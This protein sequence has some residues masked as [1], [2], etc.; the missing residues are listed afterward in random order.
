MEQI[1]E[2]NCMTRDRSFIET[3]ITAFSFNL[4]Q[5]AGK[6]QLFRDL[7]DILSIGESSVKYWKLLM[8]EKREMC[9]RDSA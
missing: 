3:L 9:I 2:T 6:Q 7:L 8:K 1:S 5:A 4:L